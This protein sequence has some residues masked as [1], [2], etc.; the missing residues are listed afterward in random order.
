MKSRNERHNTK[1]GRGWR[2]AIGA[3][4]FGIGSIWTVATVQSQEKPTYTVLQRFKG[5][6]GTNPQAALITDNS[7]NLYGTAFNGGDLGAC[8][9]A[10]C[11]VVFKLDRDGREKVLYTFEAGTDGAG[12]A[13]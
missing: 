13:A 1:S 2:V 11:G 7:G 12:P 6:D 10:G 9:G 8:G 3:L 5:A 4:V